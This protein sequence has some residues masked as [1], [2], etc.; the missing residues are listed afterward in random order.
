MKN[1]LNKRTIR[2]IKSNLGKYM[3]MFLLIT[4]TIAIGSGFLVSADSLRKYFVRKSK[5]KS[6]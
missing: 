6:C 5:E 2:D 4:I 1:P 3:S